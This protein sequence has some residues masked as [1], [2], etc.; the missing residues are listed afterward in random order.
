[1]RRR[2]AVALFL[3]ALGTAL[4]CKRPAPSPPKPAQPAPEKANV[5][6]LDV[7]VERDLDADN[8]LNL[9]YGASVA[10]RTGESNLELSAL[11][12]ID[13]LANTFWSSPPGGAVQTLTLAL[14]ARS[15]IERLGITSTRDTI[16]KEVRFET[17]IDGK[18]WRE[19]LVLKPEVSAEPQV[20]DVKP[21]EARYVRITTTEPRG[22]LATLRSVHALGEELE[23]PANRVFTGCWTINGLAAH[24]VQT[25]ARVTGTLAT[26][27]PTLIDGGIDGR[28]ARLVWLRSPNR[29]YATLSMDPATRRLSGLTFYEELSA[30]YTTAAWFGKPCADAGTPTGMDERQLNELLERSG[31]WSIYGLAFNDREQL[32]EEPSRSSLDALTGVLRAQPARRFR[33]VS[34]EF[35][36]D[37]PEP[38]TA[39]RISS[40]KAALQ[41]RGADVT[42]IEFVA[43]GSKWTTPPIIAAIQR[44]MASSVDL[45][46]VKPD[47]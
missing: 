41:K 15:R 14:A 19:V 8:L 22:H 3:F 46:I 1:V 33:I 39:A 32:L 42:K 44:L 18:R 28:V 29:G 35:R 40:L 20:M 13:G 37:A 17:S 5:N 34:R 6:P 16:P 30:N 4:A 47:R 23:R 2:A 36:L 12:A 25:G 24:L 31:R 26:T 11:Q 21:V 9:A 7:K 10:S 45:E 38:R 43:A 27:P